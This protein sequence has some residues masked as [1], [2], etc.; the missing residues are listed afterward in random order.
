MNGINPLTERLLAKLKTAQQHIDAQEPG[1]AEVVAKEVLAEAAR[2]GLRSAHAHWVLAI[3][4]DYQ[5]ELEP[6]FEQITR[7]IELDPLAPGHRNSFEIIT[8]RIGEALYDAEREDDDPSTPR[9]YRL[10]LQAGEPTAGAHLAMV[11]HHAATGA[12][13]EARK[14]A[15]AVTLLHPTEAAAWRA[16]AMVARLLGDEQ[17]AAEADVQAAA[18]APENLPFGAPGVAEA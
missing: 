8:R 13:D 16:K 10:L 6:A 18:A 7:A 2:A 5:G 14:L 17:A 1:Q 12:V 15:D 4:H 3:A 11:R 9:L